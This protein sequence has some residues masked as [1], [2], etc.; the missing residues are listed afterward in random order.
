MVRLTDEQTKTLIELL[1]S[2][3]IEVGSD[4]YHIR[5]DLHRQITDN[6]YAGTWHE[7]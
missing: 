7:E 6:Y 2:S 3:N 5:E 4:L 1:D